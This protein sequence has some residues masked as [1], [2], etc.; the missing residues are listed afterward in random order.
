MIWWTW[1][2]SWI[3]DQCYSSFLYLQ[4]IWYVFTGC[5]SEQRSKGQQRRI[6]GC[7]QI[8]GCMWGECVVS[9][10]WVRWVGWVSGECWLAYPWCPL[11]WAWGML[12]TR[13]ALL[14]RSCVREAPGRSGPSALRPACCT[15]VIMGRPKRQTEGWQSW[16]MSCMAVKTEVTQ[17]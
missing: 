5:N 14:S 4:L 9:A 1:L 11:L 13:W 10:W 7:L 6:S 16:K 15:L 8:S 2:L 17:F 3:R 12:G